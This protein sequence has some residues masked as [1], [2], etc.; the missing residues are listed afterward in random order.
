MVMN[1]EALDVLLVEDEFLIRWAISRTLA[2]AGHQVREAADAASAIRLLMHWPPPDV[3]LVDYRLPDSQGLSLVRSVRA[4]APNA[5]LVMMSADPPADTTGCS[6]YGVARIMQ[7][8]FDMGD[9]E[10]ALRTAVVARH[11]AVRA[12][13]ERR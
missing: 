4:L 5:A 10:P 12:E 7:K 13:G 3:V 9:V 1:P 2:I 11:Q 6:E 8:P